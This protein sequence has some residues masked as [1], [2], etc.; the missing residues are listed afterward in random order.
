MSF[1]PRFHRHRPL[2]HNLRAITGDG[3]AHAVMVG[4]GEANIVAFGLAIGLSGGTAGLLGTIPFLGGATL[5]LISPWAVHWLGS[6][7]AWVVLC[8]ALQAAAFLPLAIVAHI[9]AAPTA[10]LFAVVTFYWAAAMGAGPAWNTWVG[11]LIPERIRARYFAQRA[12]WT[13]LCV[14]GALIVAGLILERWQRVGRPLEAFALLFAVAF[15]CRSLSTLFNASLSE[16]D[17]LPAGLRT[18]SLPEMVRRIRDGEEGRLLLY[19]VLVQVAVQVAGP[20]FTPYM[21]SELHFSYAQFIAISAV[22]FAAKILAFPMIGKLA[23]RVGAQTTMTIGGVAIVPLS[24]F[25][26]LSDSFAFLLPLQCLT[27]VAWGVFELGSLLLFFEA[28]RAEERTS[29]LTTFNLANAAAIALGALLGRTYLGIAGE[30]PQAYLVLFGA[31]SI[32]RAAPLLL[33]INLKR[34][35][36]PIVPLATRT[37]A[38]VPQAGSLERPIVASLPQP[39]PVPAE[40]DR[41]QTREALRAHRP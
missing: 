6:H 21:L 9:G 17:P 3:A 23:A 11:T 13:Q 16:P 15:V 30:N 35:E 34:R 7:R 38:V 28:L 29:L 40:M 36:A 14:F 20:F 25:W 18:V 31:S 27:G 26:L 19:L 2:R 10:F 22:A 4:L 12:R 39:H 37:D 32:L 1:I 5:Q 8:T 41:R 24:A 33:L